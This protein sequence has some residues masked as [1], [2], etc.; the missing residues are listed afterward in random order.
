MP[1]TRLY[2]ASGIEG[3]STRTAM[4]RAAHGLDWILRQF[5]VQITSTALRFSIC[6][7]DSRQA[8]RV[9]FQRENA[10]GSASFARSF[11]P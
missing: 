8:P 6:H 5:A 4:T 11:G 1:E 9:T 2:V 7:W 10:C 3:E